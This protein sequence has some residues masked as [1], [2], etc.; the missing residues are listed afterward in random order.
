MKERSEQMDKKILEKR[1]R[2]ELE[3]MLGK[4]VIGRN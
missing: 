4:K 2:D 1:K 3:E